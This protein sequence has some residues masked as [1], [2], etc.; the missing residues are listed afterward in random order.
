MEAS[1]MT[2][3]GLS[4]VSYLRK[5]QR[6]EL[7]PACDWWMRGARYGEIVSVSDKHGTVR[8]RLDA[9]GRV[10][11]LSARNVGEVL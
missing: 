9:T 8:V 3:H 7:H 1:N 5:G 2:D 6:I 4:S 10:V 11:T